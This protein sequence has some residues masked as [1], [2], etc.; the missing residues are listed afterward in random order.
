[1][2]RELAEDP[3]PQQSDHNRS[4]ANNLV[5]FHDRSQGVHGGTSYGA[6]HVEGL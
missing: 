3:I 6:V 1:M 4:T 5:Y 2:I